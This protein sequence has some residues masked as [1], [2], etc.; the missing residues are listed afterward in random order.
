MSEGQTW[1]SEDTRLLVS[2]SFFGAGSHLHLLTVVIQRTNSWRLLRGR[3]HCLRCGR[4]VPCSDF[5][6][7]CGI[8]VQGTNRSGCHQNFGKPDRISG[9]DEVRHISGKVLYRHDKR[10][11]Y[12]GYT[13]HARIVF[14]IL[15]GKV[16]DVGLIP[17]TGAKNKGHF[18]VRKANQTS[19]F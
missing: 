14:G 18:G 10:L 3:T 9:P 11:T 5:L 17:V 8:R 2:K 4:F 12:S 16:R 15:R 19:K 13:S 1:S 7:N 6:F